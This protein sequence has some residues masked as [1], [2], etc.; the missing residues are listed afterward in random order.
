MDCV[1]VSAVRE[2]LKLMAD[3]EIISFGGGCPAEDTFEPVVIR[4]ILGELLVS[5]PNEMLQY[6]VTEGWMPLREAFVEHV[7]APKGLSLL[8]PKKEAL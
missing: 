6:G 1:G 7:A 8:K 2:I 4:R 5:R 3:P